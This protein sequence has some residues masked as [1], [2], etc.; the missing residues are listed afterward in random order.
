[1][2]GLA[3]LSFFKKTKIWNCPLGGAFAHSFKAP[4]WGDWGFL[5]CAHPSFFSTASKPIFLLYHKTL[6]RKTKNLLKTKFVIETK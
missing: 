3:I 1:M 2:H 6:N 5:I 4:R